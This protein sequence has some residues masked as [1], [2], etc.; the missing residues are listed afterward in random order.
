[1]SEPEI[2]DGSWQAERLYVLRTIEDLKAEQ[3]RQSE[4]TAIDRAALIEKG[5]K[6][7]DAAHDKIRLLQNER[8]TLRIKNWLLGG[9]VGLVG[10]GLLEVFKWFANGWHK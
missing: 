3:K 8:T 5:R 6:D 1:M 7:I 4:A 9:I 2:T 10:A